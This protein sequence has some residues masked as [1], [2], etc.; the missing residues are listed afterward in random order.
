MRV[1]P[2]DEA[3]HHGPPVAVALQAVR[4]VVL[5]YGVNE[6]GRLVGT[7]RRLE[8]EARAR[9]VGVEAERAFLDTPAVVPPRDHDIDLLDVILSDVPQVEVAGL[10]VEGEAEGVAE[11]VGEDLVDDPGLTHERVVGRD[12][13]LSVRRV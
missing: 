12:A 7:G 9:P 2:I 13:V 11:A 4:G 10:L 5:G 3:A 8:G 6:T 1:S